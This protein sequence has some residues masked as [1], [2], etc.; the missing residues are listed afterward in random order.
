[1]SNPFQDQLLKAGL[2]T[3]QQ[4]LKANSDK[5][6]QVKQQRAPKGTTAM[7]DTALKAQQIADEKARQARDLNKQKEEQARQKA[8][9]AEIRQ[10]IISHQIKR[11]ADCDLVYNFQH[12]NK[13]KNIYINAEM[14]QQIIKGL[15]GIACLEGRYELVPK[16][17]AEKIKQ[18]NEKYIV[19]FTDEPQ[20]T[21]ASDPY[22][23]YKI[24]DDLMW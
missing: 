3:K 8:A 18:R 22:A 9:A 20:A 16:S 6:K 10:L 7:T 4:V 15:I 5:N 2:V 19:L 21:D 11:D 14:K 24:P 12:E 1:M 13:V 23:D 17:I